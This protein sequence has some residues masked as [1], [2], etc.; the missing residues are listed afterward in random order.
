MRKPVLTLGVSDSH[1]ATACLFEEGEV[2]ACISEERLNRDKE[3]AGFPRLAVAKCLEIA[4]KSPAEVDAVGV[5]STMPQIGHAGYFQP[6]WYKKAFSYATRVLP[7]SVLQDP[8]NS[9]RIHQLGRVLFR[10]RRQGLRD[11][12]RH[13]GVNT[14]NISFYDHHLLHA[15]TGY[16][17]S[18]LKARK[19]LVITLDGSG[20]AIC[21]TVNTAENGK[22]TRLAD[23]FNYNSVC[24]MYTRVTEYL[25]MKPM[26]HEYKVMGMAPYASGYGRD[27]LMEK[28]RSYFDVSGSDPYRFRNTSGV[29][30][31]QFQKRFERD[32]K[33][34]RFDAVAGAVQEAFEEV[35]IE[36]VRNTIRASGVRDV[37]LSGGGFMNV[38]LN[39]R[40][41]QLPEVESLFIFP[42][43]GDE[44]NPIG[45]CILAAIDQGMP[46]EQVQPL[47]MID[48][49]PEFSDREIE[50]A[51]ASDVPADAGL[52]MSAHDDINHVIA[53]EL[54]AGKIVA[55]FT[56]R[57]EWGA[58]ALGNRSILADARSQQIVHKLNRAVKMRDFWMPFAPAI[59][60]E[61]RERYLVLRDDFDCPYMTIA[62]DTK[63][64]AWDAIPAGLH[65]FDRSTR[66]QILDPQHHPGFHD[67]VS[68]YEEMTGVGGVLN[69]SFNLHGDPI[70]CS[71]T[72]AIYTFLNSELDVLQME[73]FMLSKEAATQSFGGP[74]EVSTS[75]AQPSAQAM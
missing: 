4:G 3:C 16:Y 24:E 9:G 38:K 48:W 23:V 66:A 70:V 21:A 43:C 64:E 40:I 25:G 59:L 74:I 18:W 8:A 1:T 12:L 51:I 71:P 58:R 55:R 17:P 11:D 61:Y 52:S 69:T 62:P 7:A 57:M 10:S 45:A 31:W 73:N 56:G 53:G 36:W 20:D 50:A 49:G 27:E 34:A 35:V 60:E 54:A 37:V 75:T 28:F 14:P 41:S 30:K 42:S 63:P 67:L 26:S 46:A 19:S 22:I 6:A 47:G 68:R 33:G 72:D 32:F 2:L 15:A 44:S 39:Y 29:W 13:A 65:P 5:C